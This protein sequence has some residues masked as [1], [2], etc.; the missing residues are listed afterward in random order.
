[1]STA[2]RH[3]GDTVH[4][5]QTFEGPLGIYIEVDDTNAVLVTGTNEY[6]LEP[7]ELRLV[8][9]ACTQAAQHLEAARR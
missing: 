7:E 4:I 6:D 8:A 3:Y 1:M 5:M 9:K 2:E